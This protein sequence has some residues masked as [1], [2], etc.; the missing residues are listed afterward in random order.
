MIQ[1]INDEIIWTEYDRRSSDE[2]KKK[3]LLSNKSQA[4][5]NLR[6]FPEQEYKRTYHIQESKSAFIPYNRPDFEKLTT[7]I[8]QGLTNGI[9]AWHP[10][11]LSRNSIDAGKIIHLLKTGKLKDIKFGSYFFDNTPEGRMMLQIALSQSEYYS[12]KLS[13]D[14]KRGNTTHLKD[15]QW[16]G[17]APQGYLN[18]VDSFTKVHYI[19]KDPERFPILRKAG[20]KILSGSYTPM[21]V[22]NLLNTK[23]GYRTRK[24]ARQGGK[25]M[26]KSSFYKFLSDSFYTGHMVRSE[27]EFKG[28]HPVMFT[29][30]EFDRLQIILGRKGR[31]RNAQH[32]FA[33]KEFLK[34]GECGGS[35]TAEEKWQI[36]CPECKTKFHKG[37]KTTLCKSC[38]IAIE[39]MRNPK[40]LHYVFYHCTK[41][42]NKNC[43]QKSI[44]LDFLEKE[45]DGELKKFEIPELFAKWA[46]KYLN[47][48]NDRE[49]TD[50]SL[51]GNNL[52]KAYKDCQKKID[53]LLRL[54]ISPQNLNNEVVSEEE[55]LS[56][57]KLLLD[58]KESLLRQVNELDERQNK[59]LELSEKTFNFACYARYWFANGD[60]KTRTQILGALGQNLIIQGKKLVIQ[61][62]Y[63]FFLIETAKLE[64][65]KYSE[66]L[67]PA[68]KVELSALSALPERVSSTWLPGRDSNPNTKIQSLVSYH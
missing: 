18:L 34:C 30:D 20:K 50:R 54:K 47:E 68:K 66:A 3:Q 1:D 29:R 49:T 11:R 52:Q 55:Y 64:M 39:D 62:Y 61:G 65:E 36:I 56:Q 67:E 53:N 38:G 25:P 58:E 12:D 16:L 32:D 21:Q 37:K 43:S 17:P 10:D 42:V 46:I 27:G 13:V 41:R 40:I 63:P 5:E 26:S 19:D 8:E 14:V 15:G 9:I 45:I 44:S 48:V 59:W 33:Y 23:W 2:G 35:V 7:L 31:P 57:R 22:F 4:E 28:S 24:T 6:R 51:I 60:L